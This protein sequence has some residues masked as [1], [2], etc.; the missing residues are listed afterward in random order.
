MTRIGS[1]VR[2]SAATG[3]LMGMAQDEARERVLARTSATARVLD[4]GGTATSILEG[5]D[6]PPLVLL[7]GGVES[8][9][10]VWAPVFDRLTAS[11]RV[12]A[13][14]LPGLGASEPMAALDA[15]SFAAWLDGT[16]RAVGLDR[17]TLVAHSLGG[18]F[19]ARFAA[20]APE[21]LNALVVYAGPGI[22]PYRMPLKLMYSAIRFSLR[23]TERNAERFDRFL[24]LDLGATRAR[25]EAWYRAFDEYN[26]N[27]ARIKHVKKTMNRLVS[28]G[29]KRIPD[30]EL[31]R[32][33][34][35]V[36]LVWG[37]HDRMVP[38]KTAEAAVQAH[39]WP[40]HI[41]EDAAHAPHIE[42][43]E[44]FLDVVLNIL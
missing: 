21:A 24:F 41:V 33:D 2:C 11:H 10:A 43:P 30:D 27:Q 29:T 17:P 28:L 16:M 37:R 12:V 4:V 34:C 25:D 35:P 20:G 14:D 5:G 26:R 18:S 42:Q 39:A 15:D 7:H 44:A 3:M 32:I 9:A 31:S 22:G 8:G 38:L 6:G 19:A 40:L 13:P 1:Y 23:P 36:H